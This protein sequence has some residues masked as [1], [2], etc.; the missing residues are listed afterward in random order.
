MSSANK[1]PNFPSGGG[2]GDTGKLSMR[3]LNYRCLFVGND[4]YIDYRSLTDVII[5]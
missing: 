5:Y 3:I 1:R 4:I 2:T